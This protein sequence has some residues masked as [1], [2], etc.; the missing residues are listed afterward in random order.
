MTDE[1]AST[2]VPGK[3]KEVEKPS[4]KGEPEKADIAIEGP[5]GTH[6]VVTIE[7]ILTDKSGQ[8]VHLKPGEKVE[9][10]VKAEIEPIRFGR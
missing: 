8:N 10:T 9:V 5:D 4:A 7:N 6:K 2:T 3:V 1:K